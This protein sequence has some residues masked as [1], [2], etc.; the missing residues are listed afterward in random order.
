MAIVK[1][2]MAN[3]VFTKQDAPTK[4]AI[5][6]VLDVL[7]THAVDDDEHTVMHLRWLAVEIVKDLALTGVRVATFTFPPTI[8]VGCGEEV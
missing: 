7:K 4:A 1:V 2:E 3:D 6:K 5:K 8:C